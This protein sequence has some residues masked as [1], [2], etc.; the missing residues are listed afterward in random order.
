MLLMCIAPMAYA[1]TTVTG[2][3]IAANDTIIAADTIA[4]VDTIATDTVASDTIAA[5]PVPEI[6]YT[7]NR[8]IYTVKNIKVVGADNYE[9]FVL[10]G[11]SGLQVGE[12][13]EIPGDRITQAIKRF[14]KQGLFSSV[15][16]EAE[17][18]EGDNIWLVIRLEQRPRISEINYTGLKKG[19]LDDLKG[20]T[21]LVK[22]NQI[23]PNSIDKAKHIIKKHLADK[24]Y[25]SADVKISQR[26]DPGKGKQF[27]IVNVDILKNKKTKIDSL[28]ITGNKAL[29]HN[30]LNWA[31]KKTND[32]HI[33]NFFRTKK[34][35]KEEYEKDKVALIEKYNEYG[36]RDAYII[37]DSV[38]PTP[39]GRVNVY[40]DV[41]EGQKYYVRNIDWT[42]NTLY[43]HEYLD[44]VLGIKKG[45]T[46][47]LKKL[48]ERLQ[49]D[50]DAVAKLYTDQGYLFF[51]VDP[52]ERNIEGD[53]I[54]FEMRIYEGMPATIN[55]IRIVGNERVYEHVVRRELDTKPGQL[56]SQTD[57][58]RSL[59][60]LAQM[61]HFDQEKLV[62]DIQPNPENG[63]VDITYNLVTKSSDQLELSL[64]WGQTGITGS[65]GVKFTNFAIQNLFKKE[66][67]R[68]VPQGEG[69]T[70]GINFRTNGRYYLSA[71]LSFM[72]PWLGGK[73]PNSLSVN[74]FYAAQSGVSDRYYKS[75]NNLYNYYA[76]YYNSYYNDYYQTQYQ[77]EIDPN[78]YLRTFG[79][80]IGY[81][82]R[83]SWPDDYFQFYAELS[84]QAY[85][86]KN[87]PYLLI[88]N[89]IA[90]N[91]SLNLTLSR[92]SIDN[93]IYTRSGS[94]FSLS[95]KITPPYS[96]FNGKDYS[97]MS[98]TERYKLLEYHKWK[99]SA[100][101]FLP[102]TKSR[103]LVLMCRAEFG[104]MGHFNKDARSPFETFYMGGDGMSSY[105]SYET[106]YIAMRG[107]ETGSLTP[108]DPIVGR[109]LGY[110][111][112]KYTMELRYP[113]SLEQNA[114]IWLL[115]FAEAGNCFSSIKDFSPFD[116]K[117]SAGVGVR[118]YLPMFGLMGIDWGW[119]F[120]KVGGSSS[121]GGSHFH[122]VLGQ[123]L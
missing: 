40:I 51:N 117:R 50:D 19:E 27:V 80:A 62:P 84:Y 71:S 102:L 56:Y 55:E 59:R 52:V 86:M 96:A 121:Y 34:F 18:I 47:N 66:T 4:A 69:Q 45:D 43:P 105:S 118:I 92:T 99:F 60:E 97:K 109:Q 64:G 103:K 31:M 13:I 111:Y 107:Y 35:V 8:Q 16:I 54:D 87:W 83:L 90:H 93:P 76:S 100:K 79:A 24:G 21:G 61:G 113:V 3:T 108:F 39:T 29:S 115:G 120:D 6:M 1:Q 53:S 49:S 15:K 98:N 12:R 58:M 119:G 37:A 112:N 122:F 72:E 101:T 57:I 65:I 85:W 114:T 82:K 7:N 104:Y 10:I 94:S 2:D 38:V 9:D 78:K 22:G 91:F 33:M 68:I 23:T 63:T 14:W 73:R 26:P 41:Y 20:H 123:E 30:K 110:V 67:Y 42:G 11:F 25:S 89:G 95:L 88:T 17:K 48:N 74:L 5:Q 32:N 81:G 44:A 28:I 70:F 46:Y 36:Y 116:L 75:Y 77:N 106:E